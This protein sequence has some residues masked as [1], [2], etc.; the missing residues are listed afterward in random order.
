[1]YSWF[2][3]SL[4]LLLTFFGSEKFLEPLEELLDLELMS[5]SVPQCWAD[6]SLSITALRE[7]F[8]LRAALGALAL[9]T[10]TLG[11]DISGSVTGLSHVT[12]VISSCFSFT[13]FF[14]FGLLRPELEKF[15]PECFF[16]LSLEEETELE[17]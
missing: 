12:G 5:I 10:S 2:L 7:P 11:G 13:G 4:V 14:N 9:F 6:L 17:L 15:K 16:S 1:M 8:L 3:L